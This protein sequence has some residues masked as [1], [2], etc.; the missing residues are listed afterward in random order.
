MKEGQRPDQHHRK[1]SIDA[2]DRTNSHTRSEC[3]Q[4][5]EPI[6]GQW[7]KTNALKIRTRKN[8]WKVTVLGEVV[9]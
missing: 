2:A 5:N 1:Q 8:Y 4:R 6:F 9:G 3:P 7:N